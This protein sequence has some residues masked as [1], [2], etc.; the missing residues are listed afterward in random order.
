MIEMFQFGSL[1]AH[2]G[3]GCVVDGWL[4]RCR[5]AQVEGFGAPFLCGVTFCPSAASGCVVSI[6]LRCFMNSW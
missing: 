2:R 4:V 1:E 3:D 5:C 6:V